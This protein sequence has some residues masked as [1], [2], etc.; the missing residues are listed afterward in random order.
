MEENQYLSEDKDLLKELE[1][2]GPLSTGQALEEQKKQIQVIQ[3]KALLR[4]RKSLDKFD[5]TTTRYTKI[6]GVFAL[7]QIIIAL[8]QFTLDATSPENKWRGFLLMI[9]L[10]IIIFWI[11]K[12][13]DKN[14]GD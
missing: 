9:P 2:I 7:M 1:S 12:I 4:N 13:M 10:A 8:I 3:I 5:K 6:L 14:L 11:I